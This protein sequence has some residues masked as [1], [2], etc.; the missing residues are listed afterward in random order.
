MAYTV[1]VSTGFY[2]IANAPE[3]LGLATKIAYGATIGVQ[4]VQ[5]DLETTAEFKEPTLKYKVKRIIKDLGIKE[6]GLH[7]EISGENMALDSALKRNWEDA[8]TRLCEALKGAKDL[9][10]FYLNVHFSGRPHLLFEEERYR[11]QGYFYPVVGPDGNPLSHLCD[12]SLAAKNIIMTAIPEQILLREEEV[13][14][15]RE[16][17][18]RYNNILEKRVQ[19]EKNRI[20]RQLENLPG[21]QTMPPDQKEAIVNNQLSSLLPD[22]RREV[23]ELEIEEKPVW[24]YNIWKK[25]RIGKYILANS[26]IGAYEATA[27]AMLESGD[28]LWKDICGGTNVKDAYDDKHATFNAAVAAKYIEGHLLRKDHPANEDNLDGMSIKE[29]CEEHEI[30]FLMEVPAVEIGGMEGRFRLFDPRH[31]YHLIKKIGSSWIKMCL[32]FEH[33]LSH[34]LEPDKVIDDMPGDAGKQVI[35]FHLGK[36]VPYGGVTHAPIY[37]GSR[38]QEIIYRWLHKL[39]KKGL[40]KAYMLFERGGGQTPLEV[41][42]DSVQAMRQIAQFL[43]KDVKP[44]DLP[45]EFFGMS[46]DNRPRFQR[47]LVEVRNHAFD[48]LQGMLM[49]PEESHTFLGGHARERGKLEEWKKEQ[50]R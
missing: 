33:M 48:P 8:H 36:P 31:G 17:Q 23:D 41:F 37:L 46:V 30:Y 25:S 20:R 12:K 32:D 2:R 49:I 14:A 27:A 1:G 13:G 18:K 47:Q 15:F 3:L 19:E 10:F 26:E 5:V 7:G 35:L 44:D 39:K 9:G 24:L 50:F 4:F 16:V 40:D 11:V 22:I 45:P 6:V 34:K 29:Y 43:E 42:R 38:S 21:F 28:T